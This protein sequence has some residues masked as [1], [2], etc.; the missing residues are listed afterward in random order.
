ML[1]P[2]LIISKSDAFCN[3]PSHLADG[4]DGR[5]LTVL[6]L[7]FAGDEAEQRPAYV[8]WIGGISGTNSVE[9]P[10]SQFESCRYQEEVRIESTC[11]E[12]AE[13]D[14]VNFIPRSSYDW[15]IISTQAAIVEDKLLTQLSITYIGQTIRIYISPSLTVVLICTGV[16][17]KRPTATGNGDDFSMVVKLSSNTLAIVAPY[18]NCN[19][20]E[21]DQKSALNHSDST[22]SS[23]TALQMLEIGSVHHSLRV[24]PQLFRSADTSY[25]ENDSS[26]SVRN[27]TGDR[28]G[29]IMGFESRLRESN[30]NHTT[31]GTHSSNI[32]DD[33]LS[34]DTWEDNVPKTSR[35]FSN[36][37]SQSCIVHPSF[38]E[39]SYRT[40][41]ETQPSYVH[42]GDGDGTF[43]A[44]SNFI[45]ILYVHSTADDQSTTADTILKPLTDALIVSVRLDYSLRPLHISIPSSVQKVLG[46]KDYSKLRLKLV[47][48]S[49][50]NGDVN[51]RAP[52]M[53]YTIF[54]RPITWRNV[55]DGENVLQN[56][57]DDIVPGK[58]IPEKLRSS[59]ITEQSIRNFSDPSSTDGTQ[60]NNGKLDIN[61]VHSVAELQGIRESLVR[62]FEKH[63]TC[64]TTAEHTG[65]SDS[66]RKRGGVRS[67]AMASIQEGEFSPLVLSH[68][69]ILTLTHDTTEISSLQHRVSTLLNNRT[70]NIGS[71]TDDFTSPKKI[72]KKTNSVDYLI[73]I[74]KNAENA[75]NENENIV[76]N[77]PWTGI[78]NQPANNKK[79]SGEKD[80]DKEDSVMSPGEFNGE[81]CVL[82]NEEMLF[83]CLDVIV[84]K[85]R[86]TA[87]THAL[88]TLPCDDTASN[89]HNQISSEIPFDQMRP[90]I[91]L[92]DLL[93]TNKAAKAVTIDVLSVLLPTAVE[94]NLKSGSVIG[95]VLIGPKSSGKTTLCESLG[96]FL[97]INR[98]IVAHSEV[99]DCRLLKGRPIQE[100]LN[101]LSQLFQIAKSK[102]PSFICLDNLDAICPALPEGST[103]VSS[104]QHR[105][106]SL[107]LENLLADLSV[108]A[109]R[110]RDSLRELINMNNGRDRI[111][112]CSDS[113]RNDDALKNVPREL[114][115]FWTRNILDIAV[116]EVLR[117]SVYVLAT[118]ESKLFL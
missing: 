112:Q 22:S 115:P 89:T 105:L 118:G 81:Y 2:V 47:G 109:T 63:R 65:S 75:E 58:N 96:N 46:V 67:S 84:L 9:L 31:I 111:A 66:H 48:T 80:K 8:S 113:D 100:I 78:R 51:Y 76:Q 72:T 90:I 11:T 6:R 12:I 4:L 10:S 45:G 69:S 21:S 24:L 94:E 39:N 44:H 42:N 50:V 116:G 61:N 7:H 101:Q 56:D 91:D 3:L 102:S 97:Q 18:T 33:M 62:L 14:E 64:T 95:S 55:P 32:L 20:I 41:L 93:L 79:T 52:I 60:K 103:G 99:L 71:I 74:Y 107:L 87:H 85:D 114:F 29:N 1:Y 53:P 117:D 38:L 77:G 68:N 23:R 15:D 37:D 70:N 35:T 19:P 13:A 88:S 25:R 82:E 16:K 59:S 110:N 27:N 108:T 5:S 106:V 28:N 86:R 34:G 43:N 26:K 17:R 83:D 104:T 30:R 98:K 73:G 54:L 40:A 57:N 49:G 36:G 92:K